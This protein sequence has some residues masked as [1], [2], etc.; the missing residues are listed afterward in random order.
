MIQDWH[1]EAWIKKVSREDFITWYKVNQKSLSLPLLSDDE[2]G[3]IHDSHVLPKE[4]LKLIPDAQTETDNTGS[5]AA[6]SATSQSEGAEHGTHTE[7]TEL[8]AE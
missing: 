2:I 4:E 3:L 7:A 8:D 1:K 6:D 5:A